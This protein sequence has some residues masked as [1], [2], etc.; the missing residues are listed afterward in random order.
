MPR[1]LTPYATFKEVKALAGI[2]SDDIDQDA[3]INA[4]LLTATDYLERRTG[5][6]FVGATLAVVHDWQETRRLK[7]N[8]DLL[9]VTS[10]VN[11]DGTTMSNANFLYYPLGGPPYG[12]ILLVRTAAESFTYMDGPEQAITVTGLWGYSETP[13]PLIIT[14]CQTLVVQALN[15][16][17]DAGLREVETEFARRS[18]DR[19]DHPIVSRAIAA[20][21]RVRIG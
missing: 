20:F 4:L 10:V 14:A 18:F 11:G 15:E 5:R 2:P 9:S 12:S 13:P 16:L 21:R 7:L 6:W 1:E 8:Y 19:A 17:R 3:L